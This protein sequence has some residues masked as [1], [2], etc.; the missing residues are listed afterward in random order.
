MSVMLPDVSAF[1]KSTGADLRDEMWDGVLHMP[2]MPLN[3]HQDFSGDL[4]DY[5]KHYW[6]RAI[7]AKVYPEVNLASIGGWPNDYRIPDILMLTRKNFGID[8]GTHFEGPADGV[9]EIH[10]PGDEAYEKLEFYAKLGVG[11]VWI[12]HRDTKV[13]EIYLLK[14]GG[15]VKQRAVAGWVRSPLTG[16]EMKKGKPGKLA[17]RKVGDDS[18]RADLPEY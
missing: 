13:P 1:R 2:P 7:R 12:I 17:I 8:K 15:Y 16:L 10:S 14:N 18:T 4:R 6:A 11:E 5:L 9:V 3:K